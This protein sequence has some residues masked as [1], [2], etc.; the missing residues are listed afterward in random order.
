ML[1][2][3]GSHADEFVL[4]R[5]HAPALNAWLA[6]K[7]GWVLYVDSE[8]ARLRK[9]PADLAD[10]TRGV[11]G[12]R[13]FNRRRYTLLCLALAALGQGERQTTLGRLF[14]G[15]LRLAS[16]DPALAEA[17]LRLDPNL[18]DHRRDLVEAVRLMMELGLLHQVDGND[19]AYVGGQGDVLYT[20]NRSA[21]SWVLNV[22]RSPVTMESI[23]FEERLAGITQEPL[24]ATPEG[25][26]RKIRLYLNRKLLD[27][28]IVYHDRLDEEQRAYLHG[29]RSKITREIEEM[30]GLC[31]EVRRE[32]IAMVDERDDLT[33]L[34]MSKEGTEGHIA[35]LVAEYLAGCL[36]RQGAR[37]VGRIGLL[38]E[39]SR[40]TAKYGK[41]WR[42]DARA[43]E[44]AKGLLEDA[45]NRLH[46]LDLIEPGEEGVVPLPAL[47]RYALEKP[48]ISG[49]DHL[50][51]GADL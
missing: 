26:N 18:R 28:P 8:T 23:D 46:A 1:T 42:K 20:V 33:D 44:S 35:L 45:L 48:L 38:R 5:R 40:L 19:A 25:R 51:P 12:K 49:P 24:P 30:T 3:K 32:G 10:T 9:Q 15:I 13:S 22:R 41:Y 50:F 29:Q 14:E 47:A 27:D 2:A 21:L 6:R 39:L 34:D 16:A 7:T 37:P 17:G 4:V 36:R 11:G 43:P 31:A